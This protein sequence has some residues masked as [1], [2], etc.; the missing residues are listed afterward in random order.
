MNRIMF[1]L[2]LLTIATAHR[3]AASAADV[4][5]H[6]E[7]NENAGTADLLLGDQPVLRYMYAFDASTP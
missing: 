5:F 7:N 6:W 3:G 4:V 2:L 1:A